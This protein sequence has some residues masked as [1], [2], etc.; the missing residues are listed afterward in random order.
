MFRYVCVDDMRCN[1][2]LKRGVKNALGGSSTGDWAS[3]REVF[4]FSACFFQGYSR[5]HWRGRWA[6][7]WPHYQHT[8]TSRTALAQSVSPLSFSQL[9]SLPVHVTL[10]IQ[11][12][13]VGFVECSE[14]PRSHEHTHW[15]KK[16]RNPHMHQ[17]L[18]PAWIWSTHRFKNGLITWH[19]CLVNVI[20]TSH[21]SNS[22]W[23]VNM[24]MSV[25]TILTFRLL[26]HVVLSASELYFMPQLFVFLSLSSDI[27]K[28]CKLLMSVWCGHDSLEMQSYSRFWPHLYDVK[29]CVACRRLISVT[30]RRTRQQDWSRKKRRRMWTMT[31]TG[32][33]SLLPLKRSS[34]RFLLLTTLR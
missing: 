15:G 30:W 27:Q 6:S 32:T 16:K 21:L 24:P 25:L 9:I 2:R 4:F 1:G 14:K 7:E 23:W 34:C 5:W 19:K 17:C 29:L 10:H 3:R 28:R 12:S 31:V 13:Q 33:P 22:C 11:S 8:S 20:V 18:R 26:T